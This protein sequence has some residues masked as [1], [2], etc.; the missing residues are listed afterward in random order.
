MER[1]H[2]FEYPEISRR[3]GFQGISK[4]NALLESIF[5]DLSE[6]PPIAYFKILFPYSQRSPQGGKKEGKKAF[7]PRKSVKTY[8]TEN[9]LQISPDL[10]SDNSFYPFIKLNSDGL[11]PSENQSGYFKVGHRV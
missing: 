7:E 8:F 4:E 6:A 1:D 3:C 2:F 11:G 9:I 5:L 10:K